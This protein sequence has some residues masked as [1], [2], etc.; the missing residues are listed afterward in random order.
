MLTFAATQPGD[1]AAAAAL[2]AV[3]GLGSDLRQL[4]IQGSSTD[5]SAELL[6][7]Q[8]CLRGRL[9]PAWETVS[10]G[11]PDLFLGTSLC[12]GTVKSCLQQFM[13]LSPG[14]SW[15]SLAFRMVPVQ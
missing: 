15:P 2:E 3:L 11:E 8:V 12:G 4:N 9:G 5:L 14:G 6:L 1:A 10:E 13:D 7:L